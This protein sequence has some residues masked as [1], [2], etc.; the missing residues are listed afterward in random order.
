MCADDDIGASPISCVRFRR[1]DQ[2]AGKTLPAGARSHEDMM[3]ICAAYALLGLR[4]RDQQD[5]PVHRIAR[6]EPPD[7]TVGQIAG[8]GM[9]R[10]RR[11][12]VMMRCQGL[13][14]RQQRIGVRGTDGKN[15]HRFNF[16]RDGL[17][18]PPQG[19]TVQKVPGATRSVVICS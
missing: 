13:N 4:V 18:C 10:G 1:G 16:A 12:V 19:A 11:D 14:Q 15:L 2:A 7:P 9:R 17:V 5:I 3:E 6:A 8:K